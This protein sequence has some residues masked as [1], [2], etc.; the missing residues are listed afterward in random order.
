MN[1]KKVK[2]YSLTYTGEHLT[3]VK[4]LNY[5]GELDYKKTYE[6]DADGN[7]TSKKHFN[8]SSSTPYMHVQ[9]QFKDSLITNRSVF[10]KGSS[11]PSYRWEY[12]YHEDG[13]ASTTQF[14]RKDKL[15]YTWNYDCK[16]EGQLDKTKDTSTVCTWD[17]LDVNGN[18]IK[19][20]QTTDEKG[21]IEKVKRVFDKN[22]P[23]KMLSYESW[24]MDGNPKLKQTWS[25]DRSIYENYRKGR[26]FMVATTHKDPASGRTLSWTKKYVKHPKWNASEESIYNEK[27]E[28]IKKIQTKGGKLYKM[29]TIERS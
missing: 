19:Y 23:E 24:D 27:G 13:K 26:L 1:P 18:L 2:T 9:N 21:K 22:D 28:M 5:K 25:K 17:E 11:T 20:T 7:I 4:R 15:K 8:S 12:D 10:Y 3:A 6:L 14:F 16:T 29:T